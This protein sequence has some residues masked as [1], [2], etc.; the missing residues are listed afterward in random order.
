[1]KS[2][3]VHA[4]LSDVYRLLGNYSAAEFAEASKYGNIAR[5]VRDA[6]R[7]LSREASTDAT[8]G[9]AERRESHPNAVDSRPRHSGDASSVQ[10]MATAIRQAPRLA[11]TQAMLQFAKEA[12]LSLSPRPKESRERLA[13]RVAEAISLTS[14]P[15]RSQIILRLAGGGDSQTQGWIDVIKNPRP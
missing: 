6:L 9:K 14:E 11:S 15:R 12:G 10:A 2:P 8:P 4:I 13:R 3:K 1:M 5:P 7:A